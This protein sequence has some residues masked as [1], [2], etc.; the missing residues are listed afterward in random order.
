MYLLGVLAASDR[1][2]H[3]K[4][5][6]QKRESFGGSCNGIVQP[7]VRLRHSWIQVLTQC[8]QGSRIFPT[9]CSDFLDP[10]SILKLFACGGETAASSSGLLLPP[11]DL[12]EKG[13][14]LFPHSLNESLDLVPIGPGD[15]TSLFSYA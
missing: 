3:S 2:P 8:Y 13:E 6:K 12:V 9:L 7:S 14:L 1:R 5:S 4:C 15:D 10:G 11:A